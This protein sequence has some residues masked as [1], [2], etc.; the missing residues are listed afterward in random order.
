MNRR[1]VC[2][3]PIAWDS[4]RTNAKHEGYEHETSESR[5]PVSARNQGPVQCRKTTHSG[6]AENGQGG[7]ERTIALRV[8]RASGTNESSRGTTGESVFDPRQNGACGTL[9]SDG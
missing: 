2:N 6:A 5:K 9:Q 4:R 8:R 1:A 3:L 7:I